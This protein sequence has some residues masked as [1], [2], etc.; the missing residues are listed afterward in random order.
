[1]N[2]KVSDAASMAIV[3]AM[4]EITRK[5]IASKMTIPSKDG[6]AFSLIMIIEVD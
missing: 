3:Q 2:S 1:M 4:Q 6:Q 5:S